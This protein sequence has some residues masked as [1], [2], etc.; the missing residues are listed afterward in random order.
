MTFVKDNLYTRKQFGIKR[1]DMRTDQ[2]IEGELCSFFGRKMNNHNDDPDGFVYEV[3]HSYNL[4]QQGPTN[5]HRH[6]FYKEPETTDQYRYLG[7][8]THEERYSQTQNKAFW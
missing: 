3:R 2:I 4:I 8:S 7:E 6:I 5:L 1:W